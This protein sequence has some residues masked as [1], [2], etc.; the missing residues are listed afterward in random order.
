MGLFG[1][2]TSFQNI[3]F[4][5]QFNNFLAKF[6]F[7]CD[8]NQDL[9]NLTIFLFLTGYFVVLVTINCDQMDIVVGRFL[10]AHLFNGFSETTR[11]CF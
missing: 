5:D 11:I 1:R 9:V 6:H 8:N 10:K 3:N 2:E 4:H 7:P